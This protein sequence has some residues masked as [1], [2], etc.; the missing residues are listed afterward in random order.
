MGAGLDGEDFTVAVD[1]FGAAFLAGTDFD[2]VAVFGLAGLAFAVAFTAFA[3]T[4]APL[5]APGAVAL[6]A[7]ACVAVEVFSTLLISG[8]CLVAMLAA[9][10]LRNRNINTNSPP[11]R[12]AKYCA[13]HKI[14]L[15]TSSKP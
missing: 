15:M 10:A 5:E 7:S 11:R 3:W 9:N 4:D 13:P 14:Y 6:A 8:H 12:Q 1:F 2:L